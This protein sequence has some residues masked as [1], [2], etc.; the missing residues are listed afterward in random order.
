MAC[1]F[2]LAVSAAF[3][4]ETNSSLLKM[5]SLNNIIIADI[6]KGVLGYK[7]ITTDNYL[8]RKMQVIAYLEKDYD[9]AVKFSN[10]ILKT[11]LK[12]EDLQILYL[13]RS[14]V[15]VRQNNYQ[16]AYADLSKAIDFGDLGNEAYVLSC[17]RRSYIFKKDF[18]KGKFSNDEKMLLNQVHDLSAVINGNEVGVDVYD[19]ANIYI[20]LGALNHKYYSLA[21]KDYRRILEQKENNVY[22]ENNTR[23][24]FSAHY[25]AEIYRDLKDNQKA[26]EYYSM[27]ATLL[28]DSTMNVYS[29]N[30][31]IENCHLERAKILQSSKDYKAALEE[32][33]ILLKMDT[34]NWTYYNGRGGCYFRL[35]HYD[36]ALADFH[37]QRELYPTRASAYNNIALSLMHLQRYDEA[38]EYV[39][40][41]LAM[42]AR[43]VSRFSSYD[44]KADILLHMNKLHEAM[45]WINKIP[46]EKYSGNNWFTKARIYAALGDK[47]KA[48]AAV[49]KA[50]KM[51]T[52][53][54][55]EAKELL[56]NL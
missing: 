56:K 50:I 39:D 4:G 27:A 55:Q 43:E 14:E 21:L 40:Q 53:Q 17:K 42:E 44:N 11:G 41:A 12:N 49:K 54:M 34:D 37:K 23:K 3:A 51:D 29:K 30:V 24:G 1:I 35:K 2:S 26:L 31:L 47:E 6:N 22:A 45:E 19:R 18:Y 32:F 52:D 10:E 16:A 48:R 7:E 5:T 28:D 46:E 25:C 9:R 33:N 38:I 13:L 15:Y 36:E 20:K 8:L